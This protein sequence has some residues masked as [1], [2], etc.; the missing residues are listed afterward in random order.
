MSLIKFTINNK[1]YFINTEDWK[2]ERKF[3]KN[4]DMKKK[5][6]KSL[7]EMVFD[8]KFVEHLDLEFKVPEPARCEHCGKVIEDRNDTGGLCYKCYMKEYYNS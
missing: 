3:F 4:K 1:S 7:T 6:N 5:R 8:P 2:K